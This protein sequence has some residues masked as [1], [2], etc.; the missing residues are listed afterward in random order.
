[1]RAMR[2]LHCRRVRIAIDRDDLATK[3]LQ[4]DDDLFAE[5]TRAEKHHS[6]SGRRQG[7]ADGGHGCGIY[8][9]AGARRVLI[10]HCRCSAQT[11]HPTESKVLRRSLRFSLAAGVI[12]AVSGCAVLL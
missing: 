10:L 7:C 5:L 8:S 2:H 6:Q 4:L 12:A 9:Y 11:M 1:M 3:A